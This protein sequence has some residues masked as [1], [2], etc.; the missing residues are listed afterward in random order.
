MTATFKSQK[1]GT[2]KTNYMYSVN[3]RLHT[4][5]R[6]ST[7]G[8]SRWVTE[9]NGKITRKWVPKEHEESVVTVYMVGKAEKE[10]QNGPQAVNRQ[11]LN[12]HER[13]TLGF[14]VLLCLPN[15]LYPF[16]LE[17]LLPVFM[18]ASAK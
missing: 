8:Y 3:Q 11:H 18:A 15:P 1:L 12:P 4:R 2:L 7:H 9:P 17:P 10:G 13:P 16:C 14:P 5:N 6:T